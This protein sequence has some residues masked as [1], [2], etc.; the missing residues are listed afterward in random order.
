MAKQK[1]PNYVLGFIIAIAVCSFVIFLEF[2]QVSAQATNQTLPPLQ[3]H[4]LPPSLLKWQLRANISDYFAEVKSTHVGYLIWSEFPIKV[5]Y[6]R[7][8]DSQER[9]TSFG[10]WINAV[11]KAIKDWNDY[12][13]LVEVDRPELADITIKREKPPLGVSIN[14][15]TGKIERMRARSAQTRYDFYLKEKQARK[16]AHRMTIAIDPGLSEQSVETAARHELGHALGIWGHSPS[17]NDVMYFSRVRNGLKI[18]SRDINTLKKI[19]Q[20]PTRLGWALL[21]KNLKQ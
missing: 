14:R 19:Y 18:S 16:L 5:Y 17:Q 7:P 3:I 10:Q 13:P 4:P 1:F 8:I 11:A 20:Q 9:S 12:L 21:N 6:D 2:Q 15:T